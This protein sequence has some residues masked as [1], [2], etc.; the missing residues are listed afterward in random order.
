MAPIAPIG[1]TSAGRS[2]QGRA[3]RPVADDLFSSAAD[4]TETICVLLVADTH[5]GF[6]LPRHPRIERRRRGH[7]FLRCFVAALQPALAGQVDLVVHGGDLLFRSRVPPAL[8]EMALRPL[9]E[10]AERGV[11]VCLVPGNHERSKIPRTLSTAHPN[12][13]IFHEPRTFAFVVRGVAVAVAGFPFVR[14]AGREFGARVAATGH[15]G[16][17]AAV[18][19]LCMH[20]AVE[21]ARVGPSDFTFRSGADVVAGHAIPDGFAAV[22]SGHIHRSQLLTHD[23]AHRRLAAPVI[24]PGSVERTSFAEEDEE[25]HFAAVDLVADGTLG[26][27]LGSVRFHRLPARPM[28]TID[29]A[30]RDGQGAGLEAVLRARL[31]GLPADAVVRIRADQR[32]VESAPALFTAARLRGMVPPSMNVT[33][34]VRRATA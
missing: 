11:P 13:H 8:V 5:L 6:D 1:A 20:Q 16:V 29:V 12:L 9:V 17:P 26:G 33:L 2:G 24:Y 22:L 7:D 27:S 21:G 23:L 32:V 28:L 34:A 3:P 18:K 25:K 4:G 30:E 31:A 15:A 10:V 19:L 14:E